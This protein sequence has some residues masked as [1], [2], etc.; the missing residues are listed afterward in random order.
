[1]NQNHFKFRDNFT[2]C[3]E[4]NQSKFFL[5]SHDHYEI[6]MF[7]EG[8]ANFIIEE[9]SYPLEPY[10]MFIIRKNEFHQV[11]HHSPVAYHRI[12]MWI[13]SAFFEENKCQVYEK[14]FLST[15]DNTGNRIPGSIVRSSGLYDAISR[16]KKYSD[17]YRNK[18]LPVLRSI[19]VE[20]LHL[21]NQVQIQTTTN[22]SNKAIQP[23]ITYL[24]NHYTENITLDML[25]D[26]FFISKY[27]LCRIFREA[28]GLSIFEYVRKKKL[29]LA[30]DFKNS[31]MNLIDV[32]NKSG[33]SDYSSFY[34]AYQK[35]FG[36]SPKAEPPTE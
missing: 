35:E 23:I 4:V 24:N 29:A 3:G 19:L 30:R 12:Y 22:Y 5:H 27:H 33:F 26:K 6:Y 15:P 20:I 1:M 28:T 9:K 21:L 18:D 11:L 2:P 25:Q 14:P 7:Y 13:D 31:G 10:D 34:R 16:Y 32:A 36:C 17:D 8:E